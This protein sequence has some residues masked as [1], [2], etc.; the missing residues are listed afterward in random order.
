[1]SGGRYFVSVELVRV[2]EIM[3]IDSLELLWF[4]CWSLRAR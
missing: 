4:L 1:M 2:F 3:N